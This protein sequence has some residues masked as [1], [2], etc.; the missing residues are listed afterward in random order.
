MNT[1]RQ[2]GGAAAAFAVINLVACAAP[3]TPRA[4]RND[5]KQQQLEQMEKA[6]QRNDDRAVR[7]Q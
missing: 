7:V 6:G 1:L 2:L 5:A 4:E 3:D